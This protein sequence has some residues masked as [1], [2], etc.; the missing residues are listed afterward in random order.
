MKL[1]SW[2]AKESLTVTDFSRRL[3]K[4]QATIARYAS[5]DRIPE[6]S[7]MVQIAIETGGEVM[8]NDFYDIPPSVLAQAVL[9]SPGVAR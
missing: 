3:G 2:L 9:L 8:P 5:R 7:I 4:P 6:P 1:D